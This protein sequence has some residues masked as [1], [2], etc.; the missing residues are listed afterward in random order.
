MRFDLTREKLLEV[1]LIMKMKSRL[2]SAQES[3]DL[4]DNLVRNFEER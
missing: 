4:N 2:Q 3:I 1:N